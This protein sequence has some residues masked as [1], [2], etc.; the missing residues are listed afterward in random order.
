M[1]YYLTDVAELPYP[2]TMGERPHQ[3]GRPS[4]CPLALSRVLRTTSAH[5]GQDGYRELFTDTA[6]AERRQVCDVHAGDWAAVL[7]AVTAFLEPFPPTAD[8]TA[9]YRARKE[10]PRVTGLAR[11]DRILAQ[12]LLNTHDPIKYFLNAHGHLESIGQH[13]IC[14]ARTAGVAAVPVWFDAST[15]RPPRTAALMQRG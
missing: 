10:D 2:H 1:P 4:N 8:P 5:P 7:P 14:W 11:A 15:V 6:I 13:R 12:A 9:I 3:D